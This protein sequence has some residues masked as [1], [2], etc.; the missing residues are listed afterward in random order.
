MAEF[1]ILMYGWRCWSE[2]R[3]RC[4]SR[5]RV[6]GSPQPFCSPIESF[7]IFSVQEICVELLFLHERCV[8][9]ERGVKLN[10]IYCVLLLL[11]ALAA[12]SDCCPNVAVWWGGE[13]DKNLAA[14]LNIN[15]CFWLHGRCLFVFPVIVLLSALLIIYRKIQELR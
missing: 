7:I 9:R 11:F 12:A 3:G 2:P 6:L 8:G 15:D 4:A 5:R 13:E 10:E 14:G 1:N